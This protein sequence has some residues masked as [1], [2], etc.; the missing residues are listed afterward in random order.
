[1]AAM[2]CYTGRRRSHDGIE[3]FVRRLGRNLRFQRYRYR[4]SDPENADG[5]DLKLGRF[6]GVV[7]TCMEYF[8]INIT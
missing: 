6:W 8:F 7:W 1:M 3:N 2:A 5:V 4:K